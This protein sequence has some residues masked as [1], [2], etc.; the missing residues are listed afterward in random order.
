M[1]KIFV[2]FGLFALVA[3]VCEYSSSSY[4]PFCDGFCK[5]EDEE[6]NAAVARCCK[7][8]IIRADGVCE[9]TKAVISQD[10]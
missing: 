9:C 7:V 3:C 10:Y 8:R 1:L 2:I 6:R 5:Y 4:H